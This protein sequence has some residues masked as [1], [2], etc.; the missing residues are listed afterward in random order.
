MLVATSSSSPRSSLYVS[1]ALTVLKIMRRSR[2]R[3]F[4]SSSGNVSSFFIMSLPS[5]EE[6][7]ITF[8][9]TPS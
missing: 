2:R 5:L 6:G 7:S 8:I 1:I 4:L 9:S 3:R